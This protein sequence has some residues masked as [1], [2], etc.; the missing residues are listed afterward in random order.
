MIFA[1]LAKE[2][3]HETQREETVSGEIEAGGRV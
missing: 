2:S 3:V 1:P